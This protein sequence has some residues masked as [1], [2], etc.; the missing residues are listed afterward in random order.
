MT[1]AT[2]RAAAATRDAFT[3]MLAE[4]EDDDVDMLTRPTVPPPPIK[5]TPLPAPGPTFWMSY[6]NGHAPPWE[7]RP[8]DPRTFPQAC[9]C[10]TC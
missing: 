8:G 7:P 6:R 2:C 3:A 10:T 1:L 5:R 4:L 9:W